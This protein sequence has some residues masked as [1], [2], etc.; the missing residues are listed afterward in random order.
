VYIESDAEASER[1]ES[2]RWLR[3]FRPSLQ[4]NPSV[5]NHSK[6]RCQRIRAETFDDLDIV[7]ANNP[8]NR[9]L[10]APSRISPSPLLLLQ[11]P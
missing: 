2:R 1:S 11:I 8:S 7:V 4:C 10:P 5:F 9:F 3:C 6:F